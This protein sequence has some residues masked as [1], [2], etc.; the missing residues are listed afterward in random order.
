M[1]LKK[2]ALIFLA[3]AAFIWSGCAATPETPS[4]EHQ[5]TGIERASGLFSPGKYRAIIIEDLDNDGNLDVVAGS[6]VPGG[7][8][9]WY[10]DGRGGLQEP[11]FLPFK[12]DV[13]SLAAVDIDGDGRKDLICSVQRETAGIAVW[14]NRPGKNW[15]RGIGPVEA[16]Y[17]EG[18]SVGDINGDGCPDI[19]AANS[20]SDDQGGIQ[21]WLGDCRGN[22]RAESGPT[23]RGV[24][25]DV[26]LTDL[27]GDGFSDLVGAGWGT[28]GALRI[29]YGDGTGGWSPPFELAKGSYYGLTIADVDGDGLPDIIA[30]TYRAGIQIFLNQK[31]GGFIRANDPTETGSYWKV[32]PIEA[33]ARGVRTLLASSLDANGLVSWRRSNSTSWISTMGLF[34]SAGDGNYYGLAI[35]D[36]NRDGR[37]DLCAAGF[38]Q[39]VKVWLGKGGATGI[40][41]TVQSKTVDLKK[42]ADTGA[43][44]E[45]AVFKMVSGVPDY[46]IGPGDVI[47]ILLWRGVEKTVEEVTVKPN[48]KMSFGF[49]ENLPISGLTVSELDDLLTQKLSEYI[50]NPRLDITVKKFESKFVTLLGAFQESSNK[51]S[52]PG[53]YELTG[54]TTLLEMITQAGGPAKD[55][56]LNE[57]SIRSKNGRSVTVDFY[58]IFT[59]KDNSQNIVLDDGDIIFIPALSKEANRVFVFGEVQKPGVY[60]FSGPQV[61]LLDAIS[62]A[63][64]VTVFAKEN[65]TKVVRGDTTR[66]EVISV[67]LRK[68]LESGDHTQNLALVNKDL[69]YVPRSFVGDVNRFVQ[70]ITPLMRLLIYPA[71]V[72]NEYGTAGEWLDITERP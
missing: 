27:D 71:Q 56:N 49:V 72:I 13:R 15:E 2:L 37:D 31:T 60:A 42:P 16:G 53:R 17:Y 4:P 47:E 22:W 38:G 3:P 35:G 25:M 11:E 61:P 9:I 26:V 34:P 46:K 55:A 7:V 57:V 65:S 5:T 23:V 67:S 54:K 44:N 59:H 8:A 58:K 36:L 50:K 19:I 24:Y 1:K 52:G 28:Y 41:R 64:G 62:Q 68:L 66:P 30:G 29:W 45:N 43:V 20:T 18:V 14:L 21:V 32:V 10:G 63:G 70:Q 40:S 33:D 39:G 12:G 69:V 6:S 51:R 48:G